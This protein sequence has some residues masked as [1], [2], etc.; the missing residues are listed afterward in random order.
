MAYERVIL[1]SEEPERDQLTSDMAG[2]G[3]SF[4]ARENTE[5]NV[6]NTIYFAS[7]DGMERNDLR[8]LSVL[9]MWIEVYVPWIIVDRL[10]ALVRES[11]SD[12]VRAYWASIARWKSSDRRFARL[13]KLYKGPRLDL[14]SGTEF[15]I[16]RN[17]ED[18]RFKGTFLRVANKTVRRRERDV[19]P[20]A[21]VQRTNLLIRYRIMMGPTYRSDMWAM[22]DLHPDLSPA[23]LARRTYGSYPTA[24]YVKK[25]WAIIHEQ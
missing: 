16:T 9:T 4:A 22:L 10:T 18:E 23:E 25:E 24:W 2:I 11:S 1:P 17:G 5:A 8:T 20:P 6:E 3:M 15:L 14:T 13:A 12:R 7:V 19:F 21:T